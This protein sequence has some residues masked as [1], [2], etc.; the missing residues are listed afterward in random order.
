MKLF[1]VDTRNP[2]IEKTL[3]RK[4]RAGKP[5]SLPEERDAARARAVDTRPDLKDFYNQ[6]DPLDVT[7][8][9]RKAYADL[10]SRLDPRE[11]ELLATSANLYVVN[12]RNLGGLVMPII[13]KV[14]YADGTSE[15]LRLPAEE[16]GR[17]HV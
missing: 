14:D 12:I 13:L 9:D 4:D 8:A 11:K 5:L 1:T 17:A 16:I 3:Q 2:D 6:Y 15:E 10:L 7:E